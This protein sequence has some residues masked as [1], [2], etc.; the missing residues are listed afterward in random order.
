MRTY[1]HIVF[2]LV[3]VF[4][5]LTQLVN[6]TLAHADGEVPPTPPAEAAT[7]A[8]PTDIPIVT[9]VPA[10]PD[11]VETE[12][13]PTE[14]PAA[15]E[16]PASASPTVD[17]V[18]TDISAADIS[19]AEEPIPL[20]IIEQIPAQTDIVVLDAT[21]ESIPLATQ[22]AAEIIA[23]GDPMWCPAG[24]TTVTVNCVNAATVGELLPLL[25]SKDEDGVIYF[26]T[27]TIYSTND[28]TFNGTN[29]NIDQ[30]ANNSLTLQGGWIGVTD[31]G[32]EITFTGNSFFSVPILITNW[33]G[34]VS[35]NDIAV[36][37]AAGTGLMVN[38]TGNINLE[39]VAVTGS[40]PAGYTTDLA[41]Y[42][43][44]LDNTSSL[45][46]ATVTLTGSNTF[47][48]NA[49]TGLYVLSNGK[50]FAANITAN[51][52]EYE[53]GI[54]VA[55]EGEIIL[56]NI[57]TERN[58]FHGI[59]IHGGTGDVLLTNIN[60]YRTFEGAG[61]LVS[62][63]GDIMIKNITA[64]SNFGSGATLS[65]S[66]G[67]ITLLGKNTF[68]YNKYGLN[69]Y[70]EGVV[71]VTGVFS[72]SWYQGL[73]INSTKTIVLSDVNASDN[74]IEGAR[75][76]GSTRVGGVIFN[77]S[78]VFNNN[79]SYFGYGD[80]LYIYSESNIN[81]HDVTAIGNRSSGISLSTPQNATITGVN[82][83]TGNGSDDEGYYDINGSNVCGKLTVPPSS[84][85]FGNVL[86][87]SEQY[88]YW[89]NSSENYVYV[90]CPEA[91]LVI[92]DG[93]SS[94]TP[95]EYLEINGSQMEFALDCLHQQLYPVNLPN[96]DQVHIVCPV[97]GKAIIK[98]L[99]NIA[100]PADL[101]AGYTYASAFSLDIIRG[102]KPTS[103]INEGGYIKVSFNIPSLEAGTTY[104]VLYWDN[105]MWTPLK[106]FMID[107]NG[108]PR[109]F[110]LHADDPRKILSGSNFIFEEGSPTRL[111]ISTN[112][113]G[114]FVLV[115]H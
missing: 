80:G 2:A 81:V 110:N 10:Q 96:G 1:R 13:T 28:V 69:A 98:R 26:Y 38:T 103:V 33:I 67:D 5:I 102:E 6:P 44:F 99:N 57:Y 52:N 115:Q 65:N 113:P 82:V 88:Q 60:I 15:T 79:G 16:V 4:A 30:L 39:N 17:T 78:N 32:S 108:N 22:Q 62:S 45:N 56:T 114:T 29:T 66:A 93:T 84:D 7:E 27:P 68:M 53:K 51:N 24:A 71:S 20:E 73:D 100:L 12:A 90:E 42:G 8:A 49:N 55:S 40:A 37:G 91:S 70:S 77:G 18:A 19:T 112:F 87:P 64:Q 31:L 21:G 106:D 111:E 75:L 48:A 58:N 76:R 46:N 63:K 104:S 47:S 11:V 92:S 85:T 9:E 34:T 72:N 50:I 25:A 94:V 107:E 83:V 89:D 43:A 74:G 23:E 14:L 109:G 35:V 61:L 41:G 97:S 3:T 59:E 105:G 101:P 54:Y 95:I 86:P 36:N